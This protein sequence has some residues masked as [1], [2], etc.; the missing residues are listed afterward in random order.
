MF[1]YIIKIL[2]A[3]TESYPPHTFKVVG[4]KGSPQK[5]NIKIIYQ[6]SGKVTITTEKPNV[7]IQDLMYLK[8]FSKQDSDLIYNLAATE[9]LSY[10]FKILSMQ[11]E[12]DST[13]FEIED[14]HTNFTLLLTASEIVSSNKILESF[15]PNNITMI[16]YQLIKETEQQRNLN[17]QLSCKVQVENNNNIYLLKV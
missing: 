8:G 3:I 4:V 13:K 7:L 1:T 10:P 9:R 5:K 11:F 2:K 6:V 16:Y 14:I 15:S 17:N 12:D